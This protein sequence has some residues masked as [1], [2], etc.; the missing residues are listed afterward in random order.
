MN[1][2]YIAI[3]VVIFF[4]F[5]FG[6]IMY[7]LWSDSMRPKLFSKYQDGLTE[8]MDRIYI[9]F[10]ARTGLKLKSW[11]TIQKRDDRIS[12]HFQKEFVKKLEDKDKQISSLQREKADLLE[13]GK[14]KS[15]RYLKIFK[16]FYKKVIGKPI[17][18]YQL[19]KTTLNEI[20]LNGKNNGKK[21]SKTFYIDWLK[22]FYQKEMQKPFR[23][24]MLLK[25]VYND[26][27]VT[28]Y[29]RW[30]T[31]VSNPKDYDWKKIEMNCKY[32]S[33]SKN[34]IANLEKAVRRLWRFYTG[35]KYVRTLPKKLQ[36]RNNKK[37]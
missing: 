11:E 5:V 32:M 22:S 15:D 37:K 26:I 12:S 25:D 29:N 16:D 18:E 8:G 28:A 2:T 33:N 24:S 3:I 1:Y 27:Y 13:W 14:Q 9:L 34:S 30:K 7:M 23:D 17:D 6:K 19:L 20:Y 4:L 21:V 10:A 31:V 35:E 36:D